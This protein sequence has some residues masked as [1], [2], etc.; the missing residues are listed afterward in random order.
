MGNYRGSP[1]RDWNYKASSFRRPAYHDQAHSKRRRISSVAKRVQRSFFDGNRI[2]ESTELLPED[3]S[4]QTISCGRSTYRLMPWALKSLIVFSIS[5]RSFD[6][7]E[8][9]PYGQF[10]G[11]ISPVRAVIRIDGINNTSSMYIWP[12]INHFSIWKKLSKSRE[13]ITGTGN[14]QAA[15]QKFKWGLLI[16]RKKSSINQWAA[17]NQVAKI[18]W[19]LK[20]SK[21][22]IIAFGFTSTVFPTSDQNQ[23]HR[24]AWSSWSLRQLCLRHSIS[25]LLPHLSQIKA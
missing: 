20:N 12:S 9:D 4:P 7:K 13:D 11:N 8:T 16:K 18:H 5:S 15:S 10:W 19:G 17:N 22:C 23:L 14:K 25:C 2:T 21:P 6:F 3:W 1:R 24:K